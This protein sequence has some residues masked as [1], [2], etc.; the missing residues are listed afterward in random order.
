MLNR[1]SGLM[2]RVYA[3]GPGDRGSIVI[4]SYAVSY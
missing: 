4:F 1:A 3:N 2:N